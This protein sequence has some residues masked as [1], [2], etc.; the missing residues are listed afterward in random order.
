MSVILLSVLQIIFITLIFL[1]I[2]TQIVS[3]QIVKEKE[4]LLHFNFAI[5][6]FTINAGSK[7]KKSKPKKRDSNGGFSHRT[8]LIL[9]TIKF[10]F[11]RAHVA[12]RALDFKLSSEPEISFLIKGLINIP[13]AMLLAY[14]RQISSSFEYS[15]RDESESVKID[16][17][18][19]LSLFHLIIT[20]AFYFRERLKYKFKERVRQ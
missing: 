3:V 15:P 10:A 12:V 11:S 18:I 7:E 5:I 17:V 8:S 16:V 1:I 19:H 14:I 4:F 20:A 9:N 13:R 6:A 2:L